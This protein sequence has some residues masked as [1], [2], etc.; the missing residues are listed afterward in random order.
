MHYLRQS[1]N[2][3][4]IANGETFIGQYRSHMRR[5]LIDAKMYLVFPKNVKKCRPRSGE[6]S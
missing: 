1:P 4:K 5:S 2:F 3:D 6:Q